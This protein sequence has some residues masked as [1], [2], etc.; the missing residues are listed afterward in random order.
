MGGR[1]T[2]IAAFNGYQTGNR[3]LTFQFEVNQGNFTLSQPTFTLFMTH[4]PVAD[5]EDFAGQI[6][7]SSFLENHYNQVSSSSGYSLTTN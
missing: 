7:S 5:W 4:D 1:L 2:S 3:N 6:G